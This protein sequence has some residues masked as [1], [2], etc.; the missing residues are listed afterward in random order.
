MLVV[1]HC[2]YECH[3]ESDNMSLLV[4]ISKYLL[5]HPFK[6]IIREIVRE[7]LSVSW[8]VYAAR[9]DYQAPPRICVSIG[10]GYSPPR[11]PRPPSTLSVATYSTFQ[12]LYETRTDSCAIVY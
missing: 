5:R 12:S 4:L 1:Y 8:V 3:N 11:S 10:P 7:S 9:A 6:K 2:W